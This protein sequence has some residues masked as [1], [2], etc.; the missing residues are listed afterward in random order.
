MDKS[1]VAEGTLFVDIP[2]EDD[3]AAANMI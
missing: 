3:G 2:S 1:P